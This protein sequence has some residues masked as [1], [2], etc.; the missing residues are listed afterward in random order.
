M[1]VRC[2][3]FT[4]DGHYALSAAS[5][6]RNVAV[7]NTSGSKKAK[8]LGGV[9]VASLNLGD[10]PVQLHASSSPS[11][12]Q[13]SSNEG[14]HAVAVS[15][16]GEAFVWSCI[17]DAEPSM[18]TKLV[19]TLRVGSSKPQPGALAGGRECIMAAFLEPTGKGVLGWCGVV[20]CGVACVAWRGV[21]WC[22]A[23]W[24]G[25]VCLRKSTSLEVT[26]STQGLWH[27]NVYSESSF[28]PY[29][30]TCMLGM[31]VCCADMYCDASNTR[32]VLFSLLEFMFYVSGG[33]NPVQK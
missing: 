3:A 6:D 5:G 10:V 12:S 33:C 7:W 9:A 16:A 15:D 11:N 13:G 21:G 8:K 20:W 28:K 30:C 17:P 1:P 24:C 29:S 2:I 26:C 4:A 22:G 31:S 27:H 19:A 23:A 14:F 32:T 25:V 18:Q